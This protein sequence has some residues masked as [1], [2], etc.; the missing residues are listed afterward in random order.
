MITVAIRKK[1][2]EEINNAPEKDL[3]ELYKLHSLIKE[4]SSNGFRWA[5]LTDNQK[6]RIET[7]LQ[8]LKNGEGVDAQ[9]ALLQLGKKYGLS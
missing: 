2:I 7:G 4:E 3:K 9:K 8:Q 1:L 6:L 5:D